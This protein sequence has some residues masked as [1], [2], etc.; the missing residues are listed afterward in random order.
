M[1]R[2]LK[3][4][5]ASFWTSLLLAGKYISLFTVVIGLAA[6]LACSTEERDGQ[7]DTHVFYSKSGNVSVAVSPFSNLKPG[8]NVAFK[9]S[10]TAPHQVYI[11]IIE[12]RPRL[13]YQW[14]PSILY[15]KDNEWPE[16][17][18]AITGG[19]DDVSVRTIIP[20]TVDGAQEVALNVLYTFAEYTYGQE[21]VHEPEE[22]IVSFTLNLPNNADNKIQPKVGIG[23]TNDIGVGA[24]L[25][26]NELLVQDSMITLIIT[27]DNTKGRKN[28]LP[29]IISF[30]LIDKEG[31]GASESHYIDIASVRVKVAAAGETEQVKYVYDV[32]KLGNELFLCYNYDDYFSSE[33]HGAGFI[34]LGEIKHTRTP[35][36]PST[37]T[38]AVATVEVGD[39]PWAIAINPGTNLIYVANIGSDTVSVIDGST[40]S[41]VATVDVGS[42]PSAIAVNPSTNLIYVINTIYSHNINCSVSVIDGSTSSVVHTLYVGSGLSDIAVNPSTNLIY[43]TKPMSN[44]VLVI[45]GNTNNVVATVNVTNGPSGIAIN[46]NTNFIYTANVWSVSVIDRTTN[47]EVATVDVG[48]DAYNVTVNPSTN[49]I[50]V[51]NKKDDNVSVID[52]ST[53]SVVAT[54]NVGSGPWDIAVNPSTNLIYVANIGSDTVSVIDGSKNSVVRTLCG[55][56]GLSAMAV[57]PSTNLIYVTNDDSRPGS[58]D[59]ASV[60]QDR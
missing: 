51:S 43:V 38:N 8:E 16:M 35:E 59:T 57:N 36:S 4:K 6:T 55:G 56:S 45:D 24:T 60:I 9:V 19:R 14:P 2:G 28:I 58:D 10:V 31:V 11:E 30:N 50:Y 13:L 25:T 21:Y 15:Y 23:I 3:H 40:S 34:Y 47:N 53:N 54:V 52:G 48:R 41:V 7:G 33:T 1:N 26:V 27:I 46:P 32:G 17:I 5:T 29:G 22:E 12:L 18:P 20:E 37:P 42:G 49:L 44:N 39:G